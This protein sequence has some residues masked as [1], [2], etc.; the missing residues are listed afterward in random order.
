[1]DNHF[2]NKKRVLITGHTGF[3]GSWLSLW[4]Q[5]KGAHVIGFALEP[6]TRPSLFEVAHVEEGMQSIIG[7]IR[8]FSLLQDVVGKHQPE[9]IF[10][11]AARSIVRY[12]YNHPVDTYSTNVMG[13]VHVLEAVRQSKG[14][15]VLVNITSDKC[16]E[17]REWLWGYRENEPMGGHDPYSSSKGCAELVTSAYRRSYF[18]GE[19][20]SS[21]STMIATTR[22]GNVIGGGDWAQDRLIP[23]IINAVMKNQSPIIRFPGAVRPWQHVLEPLNG[24]MMLAEKLWCEGASFAGPWNFGPSDDDAK[25]VSWI[26]DRITALWGEGACWETDKNQNPHEATYLKLDCSKAKNQLRWSPILNL[27]LAL[28]WINQWY[29]SFRNKEDM[30]QVTEEEIKRYES[31]VS[32]KATELNNRSRL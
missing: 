8:D 17:N 23:D 25:P 2:W 19:T 4:L 16:Y 5:S 9:I 14:V 28:E 30:R 26:A 12:S 10:H 21:K 22:A 6:P 7:D 32:E 31:L 1:M 20:D 29:K 3:K 11:L 13:T 18:S 27:S 15:R 24:Y